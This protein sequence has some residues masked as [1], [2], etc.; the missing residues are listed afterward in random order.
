VRAVVGLGYVD[1][2]STSSESSTLAL[3]IWSILSGLKVPSVSIRMVPLPKPPSCTGLCAM[4]QSVWHICDLPEPN[5]PKN[6]QCDFFAA[7]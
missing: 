4:A 7:H 6:Y 2:L 5:A 1:V 3:A